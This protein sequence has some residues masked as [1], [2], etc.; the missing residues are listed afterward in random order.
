LYS[1]IA[2]EGEIISCRGKV[3]RVES[4]SGLGYRIVVGSPE[5]RGTDFIVL[6]SHSQQ[7]KML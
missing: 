6:F 3:E 1:D 7:A 2:R 4:S 5:A